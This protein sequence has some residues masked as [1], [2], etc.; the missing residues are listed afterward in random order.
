MTA[1]A[2]RSSTT[3]R[4]RRN[5]RSATGSRRPNTARTASANAISVAIG[6]P[7]P[8]KSPRSIDALTPTKISAGTTMPPIAAAAGTTACDALLSEPTTSSRFNS[9]PTTKKK[10]ASSASAAHTPSER[11]NPSEAGPICR[12]TRDVYVSPQGEFAQIS[13]MIAAAMRS[14]P[15]IVSSR[16]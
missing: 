9:S 16:R 3:A 2:P 11:F 4:V 12:S 13:A 8:V 7:H 14:S 10:T 15:P 6:I 5:A 1:I